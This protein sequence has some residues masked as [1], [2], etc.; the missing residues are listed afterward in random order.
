MKMDITSR[1]NE[2]VARF[3]KLAASARFR[4]ECGEYLCDSPK[5]LE[6]AIRWGAGIREVMYTG[7]RPM[8]LPEAVRSYRVTEEVMEAVS[9]MKSPQGVVFTVELTEN[10][11]CEDIAGAVIAENIQDPGNLGTVLRTANAFNIPAVV[12]VGE[13]ADIFSPKAV[14]ASMGAV[15]RQ[16]V[17]SV[18]YEELEDLAAVTPIYGAALRDDAVDIRRADLEGAAVAIGNE[19]SGLTER[20]LAM[21]RGTVI[22]PMSPCCESLNAGAAAAVVMWEMAGRKA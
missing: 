19:G 16:R 22:I 15:F 2:K 1:K 9:P 12:T 7:E 6:E 3:K 11:G 5:L 8:G 14:R 20:L 13:C 18:S 21:C 10:R 4:R 17:R